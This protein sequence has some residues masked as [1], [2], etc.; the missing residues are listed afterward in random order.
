LRIAT[1]QW[2]GQRNVGVVAEDGQSLTP[3]NL[4]PGQARTGALAVIELGGD[5]KQ[6]SRRYGQ[7]LL[8][9]DVK[10]E[11]PLPVPRRNIFCVGR[12]Y[13]AHAK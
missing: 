12:N 7:P 3:L 6:L 11:A 13:H 10:L 4:E 9:R 1:Y 2:N 5:L 8:L